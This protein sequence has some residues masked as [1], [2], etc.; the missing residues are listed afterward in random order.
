MSTTDTSVDSESQLKDCP[1]CKARSVATVK[2]EYG[3]TEER[4]AGCDYF[5]R[6][7]EGS[8]RDAH[9]YD[10]RLREELII[11]RTFQPPR[12]WPPAPDPRREATPLFTGA[13]R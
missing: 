7:R 6:T 10:R 2:L 11:V 9:L 8:L 13:R 4:C 3:L 12:P 5:A 1:K